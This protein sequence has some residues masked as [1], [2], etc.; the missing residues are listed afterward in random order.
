M[1]KQIYKNMKL[2]EGLAY[3]DEGNS[4]LVTFC[5]QC[6]SGCNLCRYDEFQ[7]KFICLTWDDNFNL[8]GMTYERKCDFGK[9]EKCLY[10]NESQFSTCNPDGNRLFCDINNY[11]EGDKNMKKAM[12]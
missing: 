11:V 5:N 8:K 12:T 9:N 1:R 10:Y 3:D 6:I 2:W 4:Y 7:I